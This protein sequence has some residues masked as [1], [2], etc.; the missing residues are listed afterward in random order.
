MTTKKIEDLTQE[1]LIASKAHYEDKIAASVRIFDM[2]LEVY[3][4]IKDDTNAL[5]AIN[6]KLKEVKK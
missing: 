4:E 6:A 5:N 1:E 3:T 2:F